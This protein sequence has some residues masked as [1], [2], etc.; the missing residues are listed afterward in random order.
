M[1]TSQPRTAPGFAPIPSWDDVLASKVG[2][3]LYYWGA[4]MPAPG[5]VRLCKAFKNGRVRVMDS[6]GA[7]YTFDRGHLPLMYR[8][9]S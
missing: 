6:S 8:R 5:L 4:L 7:T 9:V 1:A 3:A 2:D